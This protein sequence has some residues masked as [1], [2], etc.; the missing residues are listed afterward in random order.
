MNFSWKHSCSGTFF[1]GDGPLP[2]DAS[3]REQ[4]AGDLSALER[5]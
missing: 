1:G 5:A 2:V 4:M 3:P